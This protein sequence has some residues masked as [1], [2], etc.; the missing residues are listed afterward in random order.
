[1]QVYLQN[2]QG[3]VF[4][5]KSSGQGHSSKKGHKSITKYTGPSL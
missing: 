1:M 3:Q 4:T 2:M 5:S